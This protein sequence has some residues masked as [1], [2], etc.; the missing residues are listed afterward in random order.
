MEYTSNNQ[1]WEYLEWVIYTIICR[2]VKYTNNSLEETKEL[3]Q[4]ITKSIFIEFFMKI[5]VDSPA[6]VTFLSSATSDVVT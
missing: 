1:L 4:K 6:P 3:V 5:V 2:V